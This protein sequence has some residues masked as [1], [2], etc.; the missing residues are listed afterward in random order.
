MNDEIQF[1]QMRSTAAQKRGD[2][3]TSSAFGIVYPSRLGVMALAFF[4]TGATD[5]L[6]QSFKV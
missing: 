1:R 5:S 6:W 4:F 3:I 2:E